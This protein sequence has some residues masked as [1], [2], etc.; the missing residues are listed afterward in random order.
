MWKSILNLGKFKRGKVSENP[1]NLHFQITMKLSI[2]FLL[3]FWYPIFLSLC[4]TSLYCYCCNP[5]ASLLGRKRK[6]K[7]PLLPN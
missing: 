5:C 6:K 1:H 3:A 7:A 2:A 4:F